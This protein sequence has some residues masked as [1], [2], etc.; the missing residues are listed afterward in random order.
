MLCSGLMKMQQTLLCWILVGTMQTA[1]VFADTD[2]LLRNPAIAEQNGSIPEWK[3]NGASRVSLEH[4]EDGI[5]VTVNTLPERL[6]GVSFS[7]E[8]KL[9]NGL[10]HLTGDI[11]GEA[12]MKLYIGMRITTPPG[13]TVGRDFFLKLP[14]DGCQTLEW[15]CGVKEAVPVR[16]IIGLGLPENLNR[17]VSIRN[18]KFVLQQA[19]TKAPA[20]KLETIAMEGVAPAS[21]IINDRVVVKEVTPLLLGYNHSWFGSTNVLDR[22]REDPVIS[23]EYAT[24][25]AGYPL[26]LNR[27][28]GTESQSFLWKLAI[29]PYAT[30]QPQNANYWITNYLERVKFGPVE[31]IQ[32]V[33]MIDPSAK[34]VWVLNMRKETPQDHADLCQ[35]FRGRSGL[36]VRGGV[37]WAA[38][39]VACGLKDPVE[40]AIWELGNELDWAGPDKLTPW[41]AAMYVERCKKTI[42]AIRA[43]DP[44]ARFA[45]HATTAPSADQGDWKTWHRTVL[46]ELG[47]AIDYV[48]FHPYY[49]GTSTLTEEHY[50][51]DIAAD[52][53]HIT[54]SDRI[55]IYNSEHAKWPPK[56]ADRPWE[57]TW[58]LT[59]A[60]MGC[61]DTAEWVNLMIE[62]KAVAAQ[63]YHAFS[64]GP[65]GMVY[66][67]EKAHKLYRTG[68]AETFKLLTSALGT[69]AVF[70]QV[71]GDFNIVVPN[72]ITLTA[73]AMLTKTGGMNIILVNR[74]PKLTRNISFRFPSGRGY[75][76][77]KSATLTAESLHSCNTAEKTEISVTEKAYGSS[78]TPLKSFAMPPK[79]LVVLYC[80]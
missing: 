7:Q 27:M 31:W 29:G 50:I 10:Y 17:R 30:R 40:I 55:K 61:L 9:T 35:F 2:N 24:V 41:T 13:G 25:L 26:P 20:G 52:I 49:R 56:P 15:G 43:V 63:T 5:A 54:H 68:I 70:T 28:A 45:A 37:D 76:L 64:S 6:D 74:A 18:F 23:K 72:D 14:A 8:I 42:A 59:H 65:W 53:Q 48:V 44:N 21:V 4:L 78:L 79:S 19:D 16:L 67:D 77:V 36:T 38:K 33:K 60:L 75:R 57:T 58:Y 3:L 80:M 39:R 1:L 73:S 11:Q 71:S 34:F 62:H 12:G 32:S 22:T 47:P 46:K 69:K 66:Y 51:N